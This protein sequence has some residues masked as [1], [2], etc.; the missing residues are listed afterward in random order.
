VVGRDGPA[1]GKIDMPK[2]DS[3]EI[4]RKIDGSMTKDIVFMQTSPMRIVGRL[5]RTPWQRFIR[6]QRTSARLLAGKGQPKG[7]L[8]LCQLRGVCSMDDK[9]TVN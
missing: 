4:L 2:L 8:S 1:R 6:L 3:M 7:V 5:R 9:R